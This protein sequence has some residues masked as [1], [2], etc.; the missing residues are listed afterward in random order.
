MVGSFPAPGGTCRA[1]AA[2]L[3]HLFCG[4]PV[5]GRIYV[6]ELS[7][8]LVRDAFMAPGGGTERVD[9]LAFNPVTRELFIA[10][11]GENIIYV[12]RVTL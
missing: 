8:H 3:G 1:L 9:G 12:G 6:V 5:T 4:N 7:T 2:G 11:Q 10:N